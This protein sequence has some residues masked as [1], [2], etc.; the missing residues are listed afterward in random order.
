MDRSEA[1]ALLHAYLEAYRTRSHD[2]L[3]ELLMA[4]V[5]EE[6]AG[7][8]GKHYQVLVQAS[9]PE[10]PGGDLR[11]V[12]GIDDRGW[13]EFAPLIQSFIVPATRARS[14]W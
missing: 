13:Q 4:P 12:G 6:I 11:V 14:D 1:A 7:P 5:S 3:R 8:G 10:A 9:W 2:E